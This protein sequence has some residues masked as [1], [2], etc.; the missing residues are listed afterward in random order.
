TLGRI[1]EMTRLQSRSR[2]KRCQCSGR[3]C[4]A[5]PYNYDA[6]SITPRRDAGRPGRALVVNR[7]S[8]NRS[9]TVPPKF[10]FIMICAIMPE[11]H[12]P[13]WYLSRRGIENSWRIEFSV[14]F[15]LRNG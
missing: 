4:T 3:S 9:F 1:C 10:I 15:Q 13:V 6:T 5:H 8:Q 7:T 12:E 2:G 11:E 14:G